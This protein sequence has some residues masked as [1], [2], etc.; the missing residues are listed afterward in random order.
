VPEGPEIRRA[1]DELGRALVGRVAGRVEFHLPRLESHGPR[2]SGQR[3]EAVTPRAKA[4][5]IRFSGGETLYS[6]NQLYGRWQ[7]SKVERT[8]TTG[9]ALRVL[10]ANDRHVARL[11]SATDIELLD[12][13]GIVAHPYLAGL[14]VDLLDPLT[15]AGAVRA[16]TSDARFQRRSLASLLLDQGFCAGL[17][18]YLRSEILFVAGLRHE[19]RLGDLEPAA[20]QR[21][22]DVALALTRQAYRSRGVTNDLERAAA[23]KAERLPFSAY[24]HHVFAR[25]GEACWT[26][27]DTVR[28]T[29]VAG[30]GIYYCPTCQPGPSTATRGRGRRRREY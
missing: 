25:D 11:Y 23:L 9:R 18:N 30:R 7:V 26:C 15:T 20:Q 28:R 2:L 29:D 17:G 27:A 1:A 21:L 3:I 12:S 24:R 14:G 22:A 8:P 4:L 5:L 13:R 10:I 19:Q 16:V 6:H